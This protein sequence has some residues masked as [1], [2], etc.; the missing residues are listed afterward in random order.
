MFVQMKQTMVHGS[1]EKY[2]GSWNH[3][4]QTTSTI[5]VTKPSGKKL[6]M[7]TVKLNDS[8]I[9]VSDWL[10]TII[11]KFQIIEYT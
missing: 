9:I 1:I 6:T 2:S 3:G 7:T 5:G 4:P 11:I 10:I 8:Y